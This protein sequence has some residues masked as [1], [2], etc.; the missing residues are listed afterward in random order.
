MKAME[1]SR[2]DGQK[3]NQ[4]SERDRGHYCITLDELI[5]NYRVSF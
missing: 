1:G 3:K 2:K 5:I 4:T